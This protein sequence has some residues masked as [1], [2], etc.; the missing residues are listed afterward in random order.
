[1]SNKGQFSECTATQSLTLT[2]IVTS[3]FTNLAT[4]VQYVHRVDKCQTN[5][6]QMTFS[7]LWPC[8]T[9][10]SDCTLHLRW[11]LKSAVLTWQHP[12]V[13]HWVVLHCFPH[14]SINRACTAWA[15]AVPMRWSQP[16]TNN[17]SSIK[18]SQMISIYLSI[19][20]EMPETNLLSIWLC[21]PHRHE[22]KNCIKIYAP[23]YRLRKSDLCFYPFLGMQAAVWQV[24]LTDLAVNNWLKQVICVHRD[25]KCTQVDCR[26]FWGGNSQ[27]SS[28]WKESQWL[29][30]APA[31]STQ[32]RKSVVGKLRDSDFAFV[33]YGH[34]PQQS[35]AICGSLIK[36][37]ARAVHNKN[38]NLHEFGY[39]GLVDLIDSRWWGGPYVLLDVSSVYKRQVN[40]T[41]DV[42]CGQNHHIGV[43]VYAEEELGY[44]HILYTRQDKASSQLL[45]WACALF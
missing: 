9:L 41:S 31:I 36:E 38:T 29:C 25:S 39:A 13:W 5:D 12:W 4:C 37:D 3:S 22:K 14:V 16:V 32:L 7:L 45:S 35:H 11:P 43:P 24:Y 34:Q 30:Q 19:R 42:G 27:L 20:S 21:L 28:V 10:R 6:F 26:L 2:A 40:S 44:I 33:A 23:H 17:M 18:L 1:M 15:G 8:M